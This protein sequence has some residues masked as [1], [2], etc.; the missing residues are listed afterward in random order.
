MWTVDVVQAHNDRRELEA[1]DIRSHHIFSGCFA[2]SVRIGRIQHAVLLQVS[3][4]YLHLAIDLSKSAAVLLSRPFLKAYL[5]RR[6]VVKPF[7][8]P[9]SENAFKQ[10]LGTEHIVLGE[11]E[12]VPKAQV[13]MSLGGQMKDGVDVKL[14]QTLQHIC[15]ICHISVEE[16]EVR[17]TFQYARVVS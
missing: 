5:I 14:P 17:M 16:T 11:I 10:N 1:L 4:T 13:D 3:G 7:H 15:W 9:V 12:R 6:Y 8:K 2:S